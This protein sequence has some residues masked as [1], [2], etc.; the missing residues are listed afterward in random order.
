MTAA[1]IGFH[2]LA[3]SRRSVPRYEIVS[4]ETIFVTTHS[5]PFVPTLETTD[6]ARASRETIIERTKH[7]EIER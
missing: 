4:I 7:D 3:R 1:L 6:H 2:G 5:S